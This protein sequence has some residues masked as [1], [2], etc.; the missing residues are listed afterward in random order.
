MKLNV[1][2]HFPYPVLKPIN[3]DYQEASFS[4]NVET[5]LKSR[6]T[7]QLNLNVKL[8][9]FTIEELIAEGKAG[10][11]IHLENPTTKFRHFKELPLQSELSFNLDLTK[12]NGKIE[13]LPVV[14]AKKNFRL[15][16]DGFVEDFSG[17]SF[18]LYQGNILAID[19]ETVITI[20]KDIRDEVD[21]PSIITMRTN[22]KQK[23]A[24]DI[25]F[26][27]QRIVVSLDKETMLNYKKTK[28]RRNYLPILHSMI[29]FPVLIEAINYIKED[30]NEEKREDYR[31]YR[32]LARILEK[33]DYPIE[34]TRF[35][36]TANIRLAQII[37]DNVIYSGLGKFAEW[38]GAFS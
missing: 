20:E 34:G 19:K 7:L 25:E 32:S 27:Q 33:N 4:M 15:A 26:E 13:V 24:L 29:I 17:L 16:S 11:G 3:S 22:E 36:D 21:I 8:D 6:R 37:L 28:G 14:V 1:H 30:R 12:L 23:E 10:L 38:E 35:K 9:C 2:R 18:D 5:E 31:W